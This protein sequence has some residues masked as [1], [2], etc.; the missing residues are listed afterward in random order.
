MKH[1]KIAGL[2]AIA[3][4]AL[5]LVGAGSASATELTCTN[6]PGTKVMCGEHTVL[7]GVSEGHI[8][9][10]DVISPVSCDLTIEAETTN[11]GSSTTTVEAKV[12]SFTIS[13]CT[14]PVVV[15]ILL[16]GTGHPLGTLIF[17]TQGAG[18]NNDGTVTWTGTE[19]TEEVSGF[20]CIYKP[21]ETSFGT[22]TGSGTT[23]ST[24][25]LDI[26]ATIPRTGGRSGAF[27]GTSA[28]MTGSVK[29]DSPDWL[30][31]D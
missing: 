28:P 26:S 1:L 11:T 20:H 19:I 23:Q 8:V 10:D 29:F 15:S 30:D 14:G 5:M 17:H 16:N 12:T 2:A 6:P 7:H 27:C 31:I 18:A 25:T 13:G 9:F 24:P 3:A 21:N 22:L 4:G